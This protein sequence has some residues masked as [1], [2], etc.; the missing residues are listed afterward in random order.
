MLT[1]EGRRKLSE[2]MKKRWAAKRAADAA[3]EQR[4]AE[5]TLP[6]LYEAAIHVGD[7]NDVKAALIEEVTGE[8]LIAVLDTDRFGT[9]LRDRLRKV[10][11]QKILNSM[12]YK[13]ITS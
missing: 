11:E 10:L 9:H 2:A 13:I 4:N 8:R 12:G 1:P 5:P 6:S 3:E 7:Y